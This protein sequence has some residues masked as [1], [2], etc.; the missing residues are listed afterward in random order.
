MAVDHRK[1]ARF[2]S[3]FGGLV[4]AQI[5]GA[6]NDNFF[7]TIVS[8]AVVDAGS[9]GSD[10]ATDLALVGAVFVAP[11]LLFS[12]YAGHLADVL[13][14]RRVIVAAKAA[15]V[16][17]MTAAALSLLHGGAAPLLAAL[18]L[19]ATQMTFFSPAKYGILP[20]LFRPHRL[21]RA[22][23]T[24]EMTRY[25]AMIAG[26]A[27]GAVLMQY[28]GQQPGLIGGALVAIAIVGT[29]A[30]MRIGPVPDP[31]TTRPFRLNPWAEVAVGMRRIWRDHALRPLSIGLTLFELFGTWTV[32]AVL[33]FGKNEMGLGDA[34]TGLLAA[35][36]GIGVGIG[37]LTVGRMAGARIGLRS[38]L[39]AVA[40]MGG[41]LTALPAARG[42]YLLFASLVTLLGAASGW[43]LVLL[44][45]SLQHAAA[46]GEKGRVIAANNF[47]NMA[48]VM[49]ASATLWFL[50]GAL[51]LDPTWMLLSGDGVVL[52]LAAVAAGVVWPRGGVKIAICP[53]P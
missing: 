46:S 39:P 32:F 9:G 11:Y 6:F 17:A 23:G 15:E 25:F 43:V 53:A 28:G 47:L 45:A 10:G 18:L 37:G 21:A 52:L 22:N 4:A 29:L 34:R 26:S 42:S 48:G 8:L 27:A 36:A 30:A 50:G 12:G 16:L 24:L 44:N 19:A 14:K 3:G 7:K 20:E 35:F 13:N 41:A 40:M 1:G 2:G 38:L 51:G 5:L 49:V 31:A 33:L